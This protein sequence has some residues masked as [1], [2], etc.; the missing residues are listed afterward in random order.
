MT[1]AAKA[2]TAP[3]RPDRLVEVPLPDLPK[4]DG[5]KADEASTTYSHYRT[6]LSHHRT[7]LSEHRTD[8]SEFR[9]DLSSNRTEMSM[10]RTGLSIDRTRMSAERTLMS[11]IRT[12]LSLISFG[13]TIYTAF[14]KLVEAHVLERSTA[15]RNFGMALIL[16]GVM[17]LAGGIYRH[18]QYSLELRRLQADS[19]DEGMATTTGAYPFSVTLVSAIA[20]MLV[21]IAAF[22]GIIM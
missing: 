16:I 5:L 17:L 9:T 12:A 11:F 13:F 3:I 18:I 21:G 6:G 8:L 10:R 2:K 22:I 14:H 20:L 19:T 4:V 1:K 15:P 7:E